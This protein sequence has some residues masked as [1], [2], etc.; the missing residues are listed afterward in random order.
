LWYCR[1]KLF[2]HAGNL[3]INRPKYNSHT[4]RQLFN[5]LARSTTSG[6]QASLSGGEDARSKDEVSLEGKQRA[7]QLFSTW[8]LPSCSNQQ[9]QSSI[10][11]VKTRKHEMQ[12]NIGQVECGRSIFNFVS[13]KILRTFE[14]QRVKG[15]KNHGP[16]QSSKCSLLAAEVL[17]PQ[18]VIVQVATANHA[19]KTV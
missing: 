13:M 9:D 2:S 1:Q 5:V 19:G 3:S 7:W 12:L 17:C 10:A 11:S 8:A 4:I 14:N 16:C 15:H 6:R 18:F